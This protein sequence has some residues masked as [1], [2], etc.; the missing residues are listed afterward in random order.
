MR[1]SFGLKFVSMLSEKGSLTIDTDSSTTARVEDD[2]TLNTEGVRLGEA[3]A[4]ENAAPINP[5]KVA[6][7]NE[8][9]HLRITKARIVIDSSLSIEMIRK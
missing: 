3:A 6:Q 4:G 9:K 2:E 1:G 8:A 5:T 7:K